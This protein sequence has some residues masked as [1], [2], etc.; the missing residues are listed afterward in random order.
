MTIPQDLL[1]ITEADRKILEGINRFHERAQPI[2]KVQM[3][4]MD[5]EILD[6]CFK[7]AQKYHIDI[8]EGRLVQALTDAEA[9]YNEGYEAGK[10]D[11]EQTAREKVNLALE[12]DDP[13][14]LEHFEI[15]VNMR[16]QGFSDAEIQ[17]MYDRQLEK[18]GIRIAT[19]Q[20]PSE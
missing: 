17:E 10:R 19:G 12:L 18:D 16:R 20:S 3:A 8:D 14:L 13:R 2:I 6:G 11:T 7:V 5:A 4:Q 1:D 9:F 15:A